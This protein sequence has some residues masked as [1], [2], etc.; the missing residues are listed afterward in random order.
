MIVL[1]IDP[2]P[3][4]S[5]FVEWNGESILYH[6]K[7]DN[8]TLL[9]EDL[10]QS[11]ADI[12]V[13]EQIKSYGMAVS[14]SVFDTVFWTGRFCE[15]WH[16]IWA[17]MP[18]KEVKMHLCG[19]MRA[20]DSNVRAALIDRFGPPGTKKAPGL[21]YGISKDSWQA[22]ALAVTWYDLNFTGNGVPGVVIPLT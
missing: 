2:G 17:R 11:R 12:M 4:E 10:P 13:I 22:L 3:L 1:S 6:R 9:C 19:S 7:A 20:K 8:S 14:D 16:G 21:T 5:A 18:R 15:R